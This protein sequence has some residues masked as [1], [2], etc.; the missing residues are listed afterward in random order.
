MKSLLVGAAIV[1]IIMRIP[2]L[3]KKGEDIYCN[4][5][6]VTVGGCAY[7]VA[8]TLK[9]FNVDYSLLVPVGKGMNATIIEDALLTNQHEILIRDSKQDNGHCLCLV[10]D[11]GERTFITQIGLEGHFQD[12]W[13]NTIDI[14]QYDNIYI[15]G[16]QL[17]SE[18]GNV[19]VNWLEKHSDK[20]IYFAPGPVIKSIEQHVWEKLCKIKPIVHLNEMEATTFTGENDIHNAIQ[21]LYNITNNHIFITLG[22]KGTLFFDGNEI[23]LI[24]GEKAEVVD[25]IGAGDSHIASIIAAV[26]LGHNYIEACKIAN[27][28]AAQMVQVQG[29]K[30]EKELFTTINFN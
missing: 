14:N 19:I 3:P 17:C 6:T 10:E 24:E 18:S 5:R 4:E 7:N 29:P 27:K 23:V 22:P 12:E 11:D 8:N 28:V 21:Q 30:M 16:Y 1:D 9:N 13:F 20:N 2:T 15:D 26:S 25:T